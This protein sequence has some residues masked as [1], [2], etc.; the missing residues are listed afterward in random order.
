MKGGRYGCM[1]KD[2][3]SRFWKGE[4]G[5]VKRTSTFQ[6]GVLFFLPKITIFI[7]AI[8]NYYITNA[9]TSVTQMCHDIG[10]PSKTNVK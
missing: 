3:A 7:Y 2:A 10:N 5:S 1:R 6:K 8:S 9:I 4:H